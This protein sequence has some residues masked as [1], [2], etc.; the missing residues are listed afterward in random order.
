MHCG[1]AVVPRGRLAGVAS[2]RT[3]SEGAIKGL[4]MEGKACLKRKEVVALERRAELAKWRWE[5]RA[6]DVSECKAVSGV[7]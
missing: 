1:K 6:D 3:C 2:R 4:E 5:E 7:E